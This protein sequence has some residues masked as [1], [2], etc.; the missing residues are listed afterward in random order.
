M[1]SVEEFFDLFL[2]ELKQNK[3]LWDY[4]KFLANPKRMPFRK[5]Y[6]CQRLQYIL[7]HVGEKDQEIWDFGCGY[8][9][10]AIF[11]ALN[12]YKISGSTLEYYYKEIDN[13]RKFWS[14]FGDLS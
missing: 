5:A 9:T 14:E 1:M 12:G 6:F 2:E 8:G 11:L 7:D 4:Y 10:T 13:R 3:A